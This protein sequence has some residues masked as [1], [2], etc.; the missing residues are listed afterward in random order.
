M[1][2]AAPTDAGST[3]GR[4]TGYHHGNLP[5][6][7]EQAALDLV[8]EKGAHGFT[9]AE[10]SRRAGV[11]VAAP[12]KHYAGKDGLLATLAVRGYREQ[13]RRFAAAVGSV[14]DPVEQMAQFAAAYVGFAVEEAALFE[15]TFAAGIDKQAH[16][17]LEQAGHEVLEVLQGP[18]RA[19]LPDPVEALSLIYAVGACAHGFAA[20]LSQGVFGDPRDH[21][22]AQIEA[23]KAR[24]REAARTLAGAY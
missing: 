24:A 23:V 6:M 5:A 22:A 15:I 21:S 14:A 10:A 1:S 3:T 8:A 19:L 11:S 4:G 13:A 17:E 7:L 20:F 18:A 9:L 2:K 16:P 12:F